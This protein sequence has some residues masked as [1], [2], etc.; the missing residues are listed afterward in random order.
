MHTG[1][2]VLV[3]KLFGWGGIGGVGW[4][5]YFGILGYWVMGYFGMGYGIWDRG[6]SWDI[7][8][9]D[10]GDILGWDGVVGRKV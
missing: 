5:G 8:I 7:G 4:D 2:S 1:M 3:F 9:W 10:G 6:D